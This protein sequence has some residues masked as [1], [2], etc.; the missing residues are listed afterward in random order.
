MC[1]SQPWCRTSCQLHCQQH[2]L[3]CSQQQVRR[4]DLVHSS[5]SSSPSSRASFWQRA[6]SRSGSLRHPAPALPATRPSQQAGQQAMLAATSRSAAPAALSHPCAGHS[7]PHTGLVRLP[8][9]RLSLL[10]SH[11]SP[12]LTGSTRRDTDPRLWTHQLQHPQQQLQQQGRV[13]GWAQLGPA[14][15]QE[16][17][18]LPL[19]LP[20]RQAGS[21]SLQQR[22]RPQGAAASPPGHPPARSE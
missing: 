6:S 16:L 2:Q 21:A 12:P 4:T 5:C 22:P 17:L 14:S 8:C 18:L 9:S 11:G 7:H 19:L 20:S 1:H 13:L 15:Y 10:S 3:A